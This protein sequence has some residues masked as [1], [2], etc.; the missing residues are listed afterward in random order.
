MIHAYDE[1]LLNNACDSLGRM[2]DFAEHSLHIGAD[3][4]LSLFIAS[5][6]SSEFERGSIRIIAG[7]SGVELVY[8]VLDRSGIDYERRPQRH[9][10]SLSDEYHHGYDLAR[11]QWEKGISFECLLY[12]EDLSQTELKKLR[13]KNGLSQSQLAKASGVPLR[14]IQQYEQRQKDINKARAEY[15]IMLSSV[16]NCDPSLLLQRD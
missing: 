8:E 14:T 13:I 10:I 6:V 16:L 9:T 4:M 5:G 12:D 11:L 7:M 2:L 1:V 3:S 15:L